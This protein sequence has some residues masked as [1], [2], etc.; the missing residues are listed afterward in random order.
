MAMQRWDPF[1]D[2]V[3]LR[4]AMDRLFEQSIVRPQRMSG[5]PGLAGAR[6]MPVDM[7]QRGSEYVIT[8]YL[9][10]VKA[11][12][13]EISAERD[14]VTLKAHIPG[15]IETEESKG[16]RWMVGELG[17]GDVVRTLAM[18][19][20]INAGKIEA[21]VENGVLRVVIPQAEEAKPRKIEVK[22]R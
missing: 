8:A 14:I 21:S 12:G 20:P 22:S 13:V 16:Y 17:Y 4:D 9:P 10:G 6:V 11:E 3:S 7:F 2:I 15:D 5:R 19:G 1:G 18:P